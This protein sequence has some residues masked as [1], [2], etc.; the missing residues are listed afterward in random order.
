MLLIWSDPITDSFNAIAN[1]GDPD[2]AIAE[3]S[4]SVSAA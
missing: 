3:M 2:G 1:A 4:F